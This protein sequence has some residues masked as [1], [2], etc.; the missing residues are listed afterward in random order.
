MKILAIF[1]CFLLTFT[2]CSATV[3][4]QLSNRLIIEAI[5]IDAQEDGFLVSVLALH[6]QQSNAA[7]ATETQDSI[8]Q[9]FSAKGE[10][11]SE[12]FAQIDLVSGL[13]PLYSQT[14]VLIFGKEIAENEP[15][16]ALDFFIRNYTLRESILLAVADAKASEIIETELEK[17]TLVSKNVQDILE[18]GKNNGL[19]VAVELYQF[20]N[21][22]LDETDAAYLPVIKTQ[23]NQSGKQEITHAGI[24]LFAQKNLTAVIDKDAA[25]GLLWTAGL[26]DNDLLSIPFKGRTLSVAVK[27]CK[28]KIRL[29]KG[30]IPTFSAEIQFSCDL[31]EYNTDDT[32]LF[33]L[34]ELE[35]VNRELQKQVQKITEEF[36]RTAIRENGCDCLS[37]LKKL[38]NGQPAYYAQI[39]D[40]R[41]DYLKDAVITVQI[42]SEILKTGREVVK[43]N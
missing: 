3:D 29:H 18:S 5:G 32:L 16:Q 28:S 35:D 2:G 43:P 23:E 25:K 37:L 39:K 40:K 20:V 1:L 4:T 24:A 8:G 26:L 19:T 17:N 21:R 34:Q 6:T 9:V 22:F 27:D 11:L 42:S 10:S 14:R 36:I 13:V 7:N 33:N 31:I 30:V 15:M 12:A 41:T 38:R